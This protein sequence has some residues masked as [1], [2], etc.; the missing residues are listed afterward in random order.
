MALPPL[1]PEQRQAALEKAA[2][3]RR[4]RA[5]VKNRLKNSGAS[6]ADVLHEGQHNDVIGKMRVVDLLQSMPGLGQGPRPPDHGA[7]GHRREPP[8]ARPRGQAGRRAGARVRA[9]SDRRLAR[10]PGWS[11]WPARPPSARAASRPTYAR[12]TPRSG[13]RCRHDPAAATGRAWTA[14]TT[15]S[16]PTSEFDAMVGGRRAARVG[17][18]PR[19]REVRHPAR[20]GRG[21]RWPPVGRRC[22]RSTSR[23]PA[24]CGRRCRRRCSS[25]WPRPLGGARPPA[26]RPRHRGRGGAGPPAGDRGAGAGRRGGVRRDHRQP[27]S[28]RCGGGVG[29]LDDCVPARPARMRPSTDDL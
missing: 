20:P 21:R 16:S 14:S 8:G 9:R 10:Q 1:T 2:A 3:S 28:S 13:S 26:G 15:G 29:S 19:R 25:S 24:R 27:R 6:I 5:E 17:G 22:W 18:G 23:A 7:A 11:C 4:E 12:T